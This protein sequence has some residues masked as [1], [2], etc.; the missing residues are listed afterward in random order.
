[1]CFGLLQCLRQD[2]NLGFGMSAID[3][4]VIVV[5]IVGTVGLCSTA[6]WL[7]FIVAFVVGHFFVFCNVFRV[8]RPLEFAWS[9]VFVVLKY[10]TVMFGMP[11]WA[12]VIGCSF[13]TTVVVVGLE[14]RRLL[15]T[16]FCGN[17]STRVASL[18]ERSPW[19]SGISYRDG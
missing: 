4:V 10:C 13:L 12:V 11:N 6:W 19:C 9:G 2:F 14:M 15:I 18:V 17:G 7:G 8:A 16:E 3:G 1:M 5:G